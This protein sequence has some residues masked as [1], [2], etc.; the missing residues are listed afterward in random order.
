MEGMSVL[1]MLDLETFGLLLEK[2]N[3]GLN[4]HFDNHFYLVLVCQFL[5]KTDPAFKAGDILH[6]Q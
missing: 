5:N 2:S 6:C 4:V 1:P 3:T